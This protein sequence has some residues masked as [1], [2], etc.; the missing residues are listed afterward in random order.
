MHRN[1]K[2]PINM[3]RLLYLTLSALIAISSCNSSNSGT[4]DSE[5]TDIVEIKRILEDYKRSVNEADTLLAKTFWLTNSE[6]SFI[7]PGGHEIGWEA[8]KQGI[9]ERFGRLFT[10]RD[11]K[12]YKERISMYGDMAVLEF[13]W[14]F[15]ATFAGDDPVPVQTKGRESQ[16]LKKID[17]HWRIVHIHYSGMPDS[18]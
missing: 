4:H 9:Y 3:K 16:V 12:S 7:H 10:T 17:D 2:T 11:L 6:V 15:D 5:E 13:Y 8:I 14:I 1:S 18:I